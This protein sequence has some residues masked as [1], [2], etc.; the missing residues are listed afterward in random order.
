PTPE[1]IAAIRTGDV[2][3][4]VRIPGVG[5]KTAERIVLELKEKLIGVDSIAKGAA[6]PAEDAEF[7]PLEQDVLSALLNLG[8]SRAAA[9]EAIRKAKKQGAQ[10]EFEA[11]FRSALALVR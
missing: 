7:N 2:Q 4:L 6:A 3:K 1:L 9:G 11:L 10:E 5:K 8:C